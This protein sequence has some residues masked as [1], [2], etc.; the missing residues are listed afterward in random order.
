MR[1]KITDHFFLVLCM[2]NYEQYIKLQ[3]SIFTP[4]IV[5]ATHIHVPLTSSLV[6]H[7]DAFYEVDDKT[8]LKN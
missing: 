4:T 2:Y 1:K 7:S 8:V 3:S 6:Q 5:M